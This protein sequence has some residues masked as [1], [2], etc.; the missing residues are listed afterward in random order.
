M[1]LLQECLLTKSNSTVRNSS[2]FKAQYLE[3]YLPQMSNVITRRTYFLVIISLM[4]ELL[5]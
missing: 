3:E 4:E 5:P 1:L 2:Y